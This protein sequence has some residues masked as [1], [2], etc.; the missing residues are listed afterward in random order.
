VEVMVVPILLKEIIITPKQ[1]IRPVKS[2]TETSK[3]VEVKQV[4]TKVIRGATTEVEVQTEEFDNGHEESNVKCGSDV[5][6]EEEIANYP[7]RSQDGVNE[8]GVEPLKWPALKKWKL[9]PADVLEMLGQ[10]PTLEKYWKMARDEL[11]AKGSK[12]DHIEFVIK[13]GMLYRKY[14]EVFGY[15]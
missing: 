1:H 11:K 7:L 4:M 9:T 2:K 8:R 10:D 12:K 3:P 13:R 6:V 5:V 14:N 15:S